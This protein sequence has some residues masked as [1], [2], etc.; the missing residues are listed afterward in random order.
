MKKDKRG[1]VAMEFLMTYG[2]AIIIIVIAV[3]A[4]AYLGVFSGPDAPTVCQVDAPLNC[5]DMKIVDGGSAVGDADTLSFTLKA[6]GITGGTAN[7]FAT[8]KLNSG[9]NKDWECNWAPDDTFFSSSRD[10]RLRHETYTCDTY[11][12]LVAGEDNF[13]GIGD[14]FEGVITIVYVAESGLDHSEQMVI[15]GE[16]EAPTA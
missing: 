9:T 2:W 10:P 8:V 15:R 16:I 14:Q 11:N 3:A 5:R 1:Q 13:G 4:L 12:P 7:K 6:G